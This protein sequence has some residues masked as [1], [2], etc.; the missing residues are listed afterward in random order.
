MTVKKIT[1]LTTASA[2]VDVFDTFKACA[3]QA[4]RNQ[5][6]TTGES[7]AGMVALR[8]QANKLVPHR[9]NGTSWQEVPLKVN[10]QN[11]DGTPTVLT[12]V[13]SND[14]STALPSIKYIRDYIGSNAANLAV[15]FTGLSTAANLPNQATYWTHGSRLLAIHSEDGST[16][17]GQF[18]YTLASGRQKITQK[19]GFATFKFFKGRRVDFYIKFAEPFE[20]SCH[21]YICQSLGVRGD[22]ANVYV[23]C[24]T[25]IGNTRGF[26][27][28][29]DGTSQSYSLV[30]Q[31][32]VGLLV[33]FWLATGV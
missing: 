33:V 2:H 28:T 20:Q 26:K 21:H 7:V 6:L 19:G 18:S 11:V 30:T 4:V 17:N 1:D 23:S 31:D 5:T 29:C 14:A 15:N 27:V 16:T 9:Y 24:D 3:A 13:G 25:E 22:G 12:N 32:G 8:Y 10:Y